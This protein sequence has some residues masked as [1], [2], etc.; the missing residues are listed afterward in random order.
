MAVLRWLLFLPLAHASWILT[1]PP[2]DEECYLL[3]TG[4]TKPGILAGNFELIDDHRYDANPLLVYVM[5][6]PST[7]VYQSDLQRSRD[8]FEVALD[9]NEKYW[10][11]LQNSSHGPLET[12]DEGEHPDNL[13]RQV[14][15]HYEV[16]AVEKVK[17]ISSQTQVWLQ[18]SGVIHQSLRNLLQHHDY[19]R[20]RE[21]NHRD[22]T[23]KTFSDVLRWT[24]AEAGVVTAVAIGQVLYFRRFL[25]KRQT[26]M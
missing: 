15:F 14:G 21:S 8:T 25:E 9:A 12:R 23:E 2:Y 1:I 20:V 7:L 4:S 13:T 17:E 3:R 5:Q 18:H 10:L 16:R 24:L 19:M 6:E 26:Y 11:C 22:V